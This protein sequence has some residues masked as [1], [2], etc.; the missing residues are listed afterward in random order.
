MSCQSCGA[1]IDCGDFGGIQT[2]LAPSRGFFATQDYSFLLDCPAGYFCFPGYWP[3]VITVTK[4]KIPGVTI[5]DGGEMCLLSCGGMVCKGIPIGA[6]PAEVQAIANSL[7]ASYAAA[8]AACINTGTGPAPGVPP[9]TRIPAGSRVDVTNDE[10]CFTAHCVPDSAGPPV[11][12]CVEPGQYSTTLYDAS[13]AQ[14]AATKAQFNASALQEATASAQGL[15][16]CGVCSDQQAG[17]AF[18]PGN[19]GL[20]S[21]AVIPAGKYCDPPHSDPFNVNAKAQADLINQL[22]ALQ[23][24]LGCLCTVGLTLA[25]KTILSNCNACWNIV[26]PDTGHPIPVPNSMCSLGAN[27][28]PCALYYSLTASCPGKMQFI[29]SNYTGPSFMI[30]CFPDPHNPGGPCI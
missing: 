8:T 14:I 11:T 17:T 5:T 16:L 2:D 29:P 27:F 10:Q 19:P 18:C 6:T 28:N 4:D 25:T 24:G 22:A 3:R 20:N 7:F 1:V 21:H 9:P 12:E 15:L 30:G 13:P 23:A 26:N